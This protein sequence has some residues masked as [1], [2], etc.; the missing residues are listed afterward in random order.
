MQP[1]TRLTTQPQDQVNALI[2]PSSERELGC[3]EKFVSLQ[4][5]SSHHEHI[6]RL[7]PR[8]SAKMRL[9]S[10]AVRIAFTQALKHTSFLIAEENRLYAVRYARQPANGEEPRFYIYKVPKGGLHPNQHLESYA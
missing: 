2:T 4:P 9:A 5:S 1:A 6:H 3:A 10:T 8:A 7:V